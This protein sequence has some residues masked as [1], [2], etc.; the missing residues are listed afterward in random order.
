MFWTFPI[1]ISLLSLRFPSDETHHVGVTQGCVRHQEQA[2]EQ[3][4]A[5]EELHLGPQVEMRVC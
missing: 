5:L 1:R 4:Q 2:E 3:E